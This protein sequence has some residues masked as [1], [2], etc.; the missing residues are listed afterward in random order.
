MNESAGE[1]G[2][3]WASWLKSV[4]KCVEEQGLGLQAQAQATDADCAGV[5]RAY[6]KRRK[7]VGL[8]D[9]AAGVIVQRSMRGQRGVLDN[10]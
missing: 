10:S 6:V 5:V 3:C 1:S 9:K 7:I 4:T 2:L 8:E